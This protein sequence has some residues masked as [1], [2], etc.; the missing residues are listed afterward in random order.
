ME[1]LI[2]EL[3]DIGKLVD[4]LLLKTLIAKKTG[5]P[6]ER[7]SFKHDWRLIIDGKEQ[8]YDFKTV[9]GISEPNNSTWKCIKSHHKESSRQAGRAFQRESPGFRGKV[10]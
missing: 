8:N 3:H 4:M 5:Y 10:G 7:F 2:P 9:F 6:S 1:D